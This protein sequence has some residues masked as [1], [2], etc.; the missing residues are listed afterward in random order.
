MAPREDVHFVN[1]G[2]AYFKKAKAATDLSERTDWFKKCENTLKEARKI[3]RIQF[4]IYNVGFSFSYFPPF[5]LG[6]I[7]DKHSQGD[8][9]NGKAPLNGSL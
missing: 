3:Q 7:T 6:T 2:I 1:L 4:A 8:C 5:L 9:T